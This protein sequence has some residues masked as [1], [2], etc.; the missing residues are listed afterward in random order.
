M[1]SFDR[2]ITHNKRVSIILFIVM[3]LFF[4]VV[5]AVVGTYFAGS[6]QGGLVIAAIIGGVY[7][8]IAWSQGDSIVLSM[9]GAREI[10]HS[11]QPQLWNVV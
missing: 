4:I 5:G 7:G 9:S 1:A 10:V 3:T 8:L 6:W 11:D 2:L